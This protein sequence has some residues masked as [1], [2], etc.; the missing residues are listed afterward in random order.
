[1]K[2]VIA[3][4]VAATTI[5]FVVVPV[6]A[7]NAANPAV[8]APRI[9]ASSGC[10]GDMQTLAPNPTAVAEHGARALFRPADLAADPSLAAQVPH[11]VTAI[12]AQNP[13]W[14]QK[15]DCG[16]QV[17][18]SR[19][20]QVTPAASPSAGA[21]TLSQASTTGYYTNWSGYERVG[22]DYDH[23]YYSSVSGGWIVP[24]PPAPTHGVN[25]LSVSQWVGIGSG[26]KVTNTTDS[27]LQ[28]GTVSYSGP[29]ALGI[30]PSGTYGFY[31]VYPHEQE[32][33]VK[34]YTVAGGDA[35]S[36]YAIFSATQNALYWGICSQSE[37]KC[38]SGVE[39]MTGNVS[40]LAQQG[41]WILERHGYNGGISMLEPFGTIPTS[42]NQFALENGPGTSSTTYN[43]GS[44]PTQNTVLQRDVMTQCNGG[45]PYLDSVS[46]LGSTGDFSI[47][48]KDTGTTC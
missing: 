24:S 34:N 2:K 5:A 15:M 9:Q 18:A 42:G 13:T 21:K 28:A 17:P 47:T 23:K 19:P 29:G 43:L 16:V 36:S 31:E 38:V 48:F 44:G 40:T 10:A 35:V 41:E 26:H 27:L 11:S 32:Q 46:S 12:L 6:S 3:A 1:M 37:K 30:G 22:V 7:A 39:D 14:V 4:M 8:A 45:T 33:I 20:Q 25:Q